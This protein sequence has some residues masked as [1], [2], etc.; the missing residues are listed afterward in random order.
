MKIG[1]VGLGVVGGAIFNGFKLIDNNLILIGY[2]KYKESDTFENILT[3][4]MIFICVP[5]QYSEQTGEYNKDELH[6]VLNL[7][8]ASK[9]EGLILIKCTVEPLVCEVLSE[10]YDLKIIH[11]PEFLCANNN[12]TDFIKQTHIVIGKTNKIDSNDLNKII[13]FYNKYFPN[14]TQSICTSTESE[15]MKLFV[16]N[17]YSVK[18]QFFNE[19][20]L[21]C[22]KID[23]NYDNVKSIMLKNGWINPMHTQVPGSD[24]QLSY[25]G[26]CF[27]KDT[28]AL[29]QFMNKNN[30]KK[31]I[32]EA[33]INERN[34]M[35]NDNINCQLNNNE[36]ENNN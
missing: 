33:C 14:V 4:D 34:T 16:N 26:M 22:N 1:I 27:P 24:G 36:T 19:L 2:D 32:L 3:T 35:R 9:Y 28:N 23:V 13:T 29:L 30:S 8:K 11:N 31:S 7:L 25:G 10:T 6:N 15:C 18:I 17:F 20:Y 5:T 21:L 12:I